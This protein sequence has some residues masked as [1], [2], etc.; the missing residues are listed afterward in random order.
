M[1]LRWY[2]GVGGTVVSFLFFL[3]VNILLFFVSEFLFGRGVGVKVGLCLIWYI[4]L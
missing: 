4:S 1:V 2:G 3:C